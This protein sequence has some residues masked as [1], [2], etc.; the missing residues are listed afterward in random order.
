[1]QSAFVAANSSTTSGRRTRCGWRTS[2]PRRSADSLTGDRASCWPRPLG[3]SGWVYTAATSWPALTIRSS[4]GTANCGVPMKTTRIA[5]LAPLSEF[6]HLADLAANEI[7]LQGAH[8]VDIQGAVE[9]IRLVLEGSGQQ[10]VC[11][12]LEPL[13][14]GVLRTNCRLVRPGDL[15]A[16]PWDGEAPFLAGL[17]SFAADNLGI[18]HDEPGRGV[19]A[20]RGVDDGDAPAD[21]DLRR[22]ESDAL[23]GVHRLEH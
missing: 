8:V 1:M 18:D 7:A 10:T 13:A 20:R 6:L 23:R 11:G 16:K 22:G 14:F 19:F 3:R 15:L 17:R 21:A 4:V 2:T 5:A 9:V 12:Q